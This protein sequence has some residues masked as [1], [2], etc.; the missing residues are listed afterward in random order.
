MKNEEIKD[1]LSFDALQEAE[2][3]T[4]KS[5]KDDKATEAL[6]FIAHIQNGKR[7]E[8]ML[9]SLGDTTFSN[10]EES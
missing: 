4:G 6:G 9:K 7:K 5:Y 2:N 3:L 1:V 8:Q 10:T